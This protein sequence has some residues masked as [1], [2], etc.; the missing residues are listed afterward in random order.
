MT[1]NIEL[2]PYTIDAKTAD[3]LK[4]HVGKWVKIVVSGYNFVTYAKVLGVKKELDAIRIS[5]AFQEHYQ[6][7][8][9]KPDFY[10]YIDKKTYLCMGEVNKFTFLKEFPESLKRKSLKRLDKD[11]AFIKSL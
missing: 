9:T 7:G 5:K 11:I 10:S 4:K 3:K 2:K 8:A 1:N 6:D